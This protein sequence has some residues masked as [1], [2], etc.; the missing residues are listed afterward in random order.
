MF[1][2]FKSNIIIDINYCPK[3]VYLIFQIIHCFYVKY[4]CEPNK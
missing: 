2:E 4:N 1:K 3:D